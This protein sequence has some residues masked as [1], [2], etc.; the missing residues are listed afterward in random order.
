VPTCEEYQSILDAGPDNI[1]RMLALIGKRSGQR[2]TEELHRYPDHKSGPVVIAYG[3]SCTM[4]PSHA[5]SRRVQFWSQI[6]RETHGK[7]IELDLVV[8]EFVKDTPA[9]QR[10]P[11]YQAYKNNHNT[12]QTL[13][14]QWAS[15]RSPSSFRHR[16]IRSRNYDAISRSRLCC[17]PGGQT[18]CK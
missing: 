13:L 8:R 1:E 14:Y 9:W 15:T 16:R 10:Q 17:K 11:W 2:L 12:A 6:V 5:R 3:G 7:Y 4:M 18:F